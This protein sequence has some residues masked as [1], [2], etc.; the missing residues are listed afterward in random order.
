[1]SRIVDIA[2]LRALAR[3]AL[4]IVVV[5]VGMM[6]MGVV[7][8]IMVG[9]VSPQALGA[10]ALGNLYFFATAIFGM[11]VLL[12]LDPVVSQAVGARDE[13]AISRAM[14]RG[15]VLS[16]LLTVVA[17]L[18]L[19]TAGPVLD[20][21]HQPADIVPLA[22]T[23]IIAII[24]GVAP[25]F[26][27]IVVRQTLQAMHKTLPIVV[28]IIVANLANVVINWALIFGKLG[29]PALGVVGAAIATSIS[30]WIMFFLIV[31]LSWPSIKHYVHPWRRESF[32]LRPL[33]RMLQIGSPIGVALFL[34]Y[35]TFG[36]IALL[37]G[38]LGTI[39][40]AGH[41]IAINLASLTFM[42]P[43]GIGAAA[44]VLVGNAI[45]RDDA[46]AARR[47]AKA[48]LVAGVGF[49]SFSALVFLT[50]PDGLAGLYSKDAGV[51]AIA[52]VLIPI[53]GVFQV[54]D[55]IQVVGAGVLRGTGDTHAPMVIGL[56]G[57][58]L[59][60]MPVSLYLG[61]ETALRA[62]GLWWGFVA[63]LA[64]VAVFLLL[65]IRHRFKSELRRLHVEEH[66][67]PAMDIAE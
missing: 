8:T 30:R 18:I 3:L 66:H 23:Y 15:F 54:F 28:T 65:R 25:F 62:E 34:E 20:A 27:F 45:G 48:A 10:V 5:Q 55:G 1:V 53:A 60:G 43:A 36:V 35:A 61:F 32:V 13:P 63:G 31:L 58:W 44:T 33:V 6:F 67:L 40:V 2:E 26:F 38:F 39:E 14:Q 7:D 59:I 51:L 52:I 4:P 57:F 46:P 49:M 50:I 12:A 42:V 56:L 17:S 24:P 64:A 29:M 47:A 22:H 37:M 16:L 21:L 9:R 19:P 11:G 41:Q